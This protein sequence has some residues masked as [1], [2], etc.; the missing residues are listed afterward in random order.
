MEYYGRLN[1]SHA[2]NMHCVNVVPVWF[3]SSL[4]YAT[5]IEPIKITQE[6]PQNLWKCC[7]LPGGNEVSAMNESI[8]LKN[9]EAFLPWKVVVITDENSPR[10]IHLSVTD[11]HR[12]PANLSWAE[13]SCPAGVSSILT[14]QIIPPSNELSALHMWMLHL[15]WTI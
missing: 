13:F 2:I 8:I 7:S 9:W 6:F 15:L 5:L 14:N 11:D 1:A 4:S 3:F 10:L 12:G